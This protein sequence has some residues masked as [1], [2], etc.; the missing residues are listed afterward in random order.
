MPKAAEEAMRREAEKR[1]PGNKERQD[2]YVYGGMRSQLG[3]R[4]SQEKKG[5]K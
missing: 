2:R 4:P 3:W 1:W 5:K